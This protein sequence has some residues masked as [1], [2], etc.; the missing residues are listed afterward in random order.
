ME[1]RL[2]LVSEIGAVLVAVIVTGGLVVLQVLGRPTD[3]LEPGMLAIVGFYFGSQFTKMV[4]TRALGQ[5]VTLAST[6]TSTTA[7]VPA[8]ETPTATN[9]Q[10]TA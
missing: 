5:A 2:D 10:T 9:D 7:P 1:G 8:P 6:T 4:S 3:G